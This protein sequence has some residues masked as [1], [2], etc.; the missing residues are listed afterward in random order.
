[1]SENSAK[2]QMVGPEGR[3]RN[4]PA[5]SSRNIVPYSPPK[6]HRERD[7]AGGECR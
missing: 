3:L 4:A 2:S 6:T 1:M 7:E 5:G